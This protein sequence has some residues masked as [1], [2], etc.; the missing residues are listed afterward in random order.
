MTQLKKR[1]IP[2]EGSCVVLIGMPGSGKSTL[3]K[4]IS[5]RNGWAWVDTDYLLESWWGMPL[6]AIRDHLGLEGFLKAE[7]EIVFSMRFY[8]T[9][10]SSGGSVVYSPQA[11]EHLAH[12]GKFVYLRA[13]LETIKKRLMDTSTRGL[14]KKADQSIED[15]FEQRKPLYEKYAALIVETDTDEPEKHAD[16]IISWLEK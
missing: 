2:V 11:M 1:C 16:I 9:V 6:Q 10:I 4:L 15:I 8:R 12:Q 3:G 14:A 5:R 7:E 13:D